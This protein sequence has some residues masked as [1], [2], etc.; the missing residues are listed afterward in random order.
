[1]IPYMSK[2]Y[3]SFRL[4][5]IHPTPAALSEA[6][7]NFSA[8]GQVSFSSK[9]LGVATSIQ[10]PNLAVLSTDESFQDGD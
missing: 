9:A 6:F 1:M 10:L 7:P 5:T 3:I 2:L 4:S 8:A